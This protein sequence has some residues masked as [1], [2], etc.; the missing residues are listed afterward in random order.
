[1]T[2]AADSGELLTL[3]LRYKEPDGV[4]SRLIE[5]PLKEK[6]GR[7][8]SAS[9]DF[10]FAAAVASFGMMLRGSEHR[11][12]SNVSAVAEIAAGSIGND[13]NGLRAEF[14]DL[15]RRAEKLGIK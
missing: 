2:D 10:Q 4:E 14:V 15:V 11:G 9:Q 13:P 8:N 3:K 5:F 7:F 1:L 6:G 12:S